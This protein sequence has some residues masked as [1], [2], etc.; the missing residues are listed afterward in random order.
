M[1]RWDCSTKTTPIMTTSATRTISEKVIHPCSWK[2][3]PSALGNE[4]AIEV[5][6]SRDMPLPMPRSVMTSPIHMM[7]TQPTV[8]VTTMRSRAGDGL[9][10][11]QLEVAAGEE[12]S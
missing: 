3:C 12:L 5:K 2:I 9:V 1:R 7:S 10:R 11:D 8:M 4:A 6:I